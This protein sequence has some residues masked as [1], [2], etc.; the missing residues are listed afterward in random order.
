LHAAASCNHE[1]VVRVL[2][3][4]GAPINAKD[5]GGRTSLFWAKK[6]GHSAI[7]QI[8]AQN[9]PSTGFLGWAKGRKR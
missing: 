1:A 8:L 4:N 2:L 3:E 6:N 9:A 7:V 5:K